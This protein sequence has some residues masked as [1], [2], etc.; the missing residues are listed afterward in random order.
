MKGIKYILAN[1]TE[2]LLRLFPIPCKTRLMKIG[3][4][5]QDSPVFLTCNYH[6]TVERVKS[7]LKG[8]DC[9]LLIANSQG[10]NV[11]CGSTGGHL[12]NHSVISV[13]KTSGIKDRVNHRNIIAPQL[14]ASG[15]EQSVI[16]KKT[17]WKII[18]GPVYARHILDF[19]NNGCEKTPEMR[20]VEFP[21]SQRVE[22][23][24]M[25][26]FPLS[27]LAILFSAFL[28]PQINLSLNLFI[29]GISF[30]VFLFFPLYSSWL[31]G[32]KCEF[33][34]AFLF[35]WGFFLVGLGVYSGLNHSFEWRF[36]LH[37][38]LVSGVVIVLLSMDLAGSTPMYKSS[39]HK[40][41][42]FDVVLDKQ[43]CRGA[44][45]CQE[46][47]PRNCFEVY[48]KTHSAKMPRA[49][50]CVRCGACII[51]CPFDALYFKNPQGDVITPDTV[52]KFK[53]NL[54]G[55]RTLKKMDK[56]I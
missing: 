50:Q 45:F 6:L 17:G 15:I 47:C 52:R 23:A 42:S 12:N 49:S 10:I 32:G 43:K 5:D 4:P 29:W 28:W 9:Y 31:L 48:P 36:W 20:K 46:V 37:W 16:Q 11:W 51:Q 27:V 22:M 30:S 24:V 18:W 7:A 53:L 38:G 56:D 19:I 44:G 3:N 25:W 8:T 33:F 54:M 21:L 1:V 41:R 2:T 39:L 40:D 13:L 14:A 34:K 55:K 26:A 35:L